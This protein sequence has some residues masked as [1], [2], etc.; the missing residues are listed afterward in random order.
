LPDHPDVP[1]IN[2]TL[3]QIKR[4]LGWFAVMGPPG[5]PQPI[6]Q[7]VSEDLRAVLSQPEMK[8]R[9][10]TVAS[11]INPMTPAQLLDYIHTEQ[12]LWK[13]VIERISTFQAAPK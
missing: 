1:T 11:Y 2:E 3:P 10:A 13:P 8:Q 4:A 6:A 7:K 9:F 5:T 12:A